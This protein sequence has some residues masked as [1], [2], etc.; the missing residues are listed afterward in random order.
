MTNNK[1]YYSATEWFLRIA[2][3]ITYLSAVADRF[4]IWGPAGTEGV[5]WGNWENFAGY[6]AMLNWY[7]PAAIQSAFAWIATIAEVV[8]AIGFLVGW[9]LKEFALASGVLLLLFGLTMTVAFGIK[10]PLDYSV[11]TACAG[12]FFLAV[13]A[14][15]KQK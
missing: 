9:K 15:E 1:S 13:V 7:V 5:T 12:S 14:D 10:P 11:F 8:I 2:L 3:A 6:A 4:G